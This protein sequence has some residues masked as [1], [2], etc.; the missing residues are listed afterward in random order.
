[1]AGNLTRINN[2]QVTDASTGNTIVGIN[3]GTKLQNYSIT[4][5][6]I[7]NNLTYGSDLT[8]TGILTVQGTTTNV[9]T[10]NTLIA[11]P[12]ITLA[13]GQSTG[14]PTVD[15]GFLG[16]RGS[17]Q[18][19]VM[20]W[21][22]SAKEFVTALSNTT[23]SNTTFTLSTYAN[24]HSGNTTHQGTTS[25]IGNIIGA[26][27]ATATVTAGNL[28]T[29]GT[30]SAAG[31]VTGGNLLTGGLIS[32]TST[33]T[34]GANITGANIL[35]GGIMSSTGNAT[36]GNI[37]TA[38]LISATGTITSAANVTGGNLTTAGQVSATANIT[39]GNVLTA[40]VVSATG[41]IS[42]ANI[43]PTGNI[44]PTANV[45]YS[46]GSLTNQWKSLY[47]AGNTI[48][49]GN[50]Q[51]QQPTGT[52]NTLQ[53]TGAD[54]TTGGGLFLATLSAAGNVTGGNY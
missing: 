29:P 6:K 49:M 35:T 48:Y 40:G 25:L 37:L 15:I 32:A 51:L 50:M 11:D 2:N 26:V 19:A 45:T 14:T 16:L 22:E 52:A 17:Q 4:A 33:I 44:I 1:M 8:I 13:D 10:V 21:Q 7:A 39:G 47:L 3:A 53:I 28:A 27:N 12:L 20:A 5:G 38:G 24:L 30:V 54:G 23:V 46:L 43:L 31:N 36:H 18:T 42:G 41:N 34:S 9:G